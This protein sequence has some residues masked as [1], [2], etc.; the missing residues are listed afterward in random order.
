MLFGA[1]S[2]VTD[3][4]G[5][6][7]QANFTPTNRLVVQASADGHEDLFQ[8]TPVVHGI[9]SILLFKLTPQSPAGLVVTNL[10]GTVGGGVAEVTFAANSLQ[11]GTPTSSVPVR[12]TPIAAGFDPT[13]LSGDYTSSLG[14]SLEAFGAVVLGTIADATIAP[15]APAVLRIPV[16]TRASVQPA[17]AT[18]FRLDPASA[19]W[20]EAGTA[21]LDQD[22]SGAFY[23]ASVGGFGQWMVG[24]VIAAPVA[25]RGC[26]V[27]DTGAPVADVQVVA[28]GVDY[29]GL[30]FA[31][32]DAAG[33]FVVP[34]RP[35]STVKISGR[36]GTTLTS[37]AA[38]ATAGSDVS[39]PGCL[40]HP[41]IATP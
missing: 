25:V 36:R 41:G 10:G 1:V 27:D 4:A 22:A 8:A 9:P 16:N 15:A 21:T 29:T 31:S 24:A 17:S 18:T 2:L 23:Q 19:R 20:V 13:L 39:V 35:E 40:N 26:V 14:A 6:F 30:A 37:T 34:V 28:E 3:A 11:A 12:V 32:T 7:A 5:I 33:A 38:V